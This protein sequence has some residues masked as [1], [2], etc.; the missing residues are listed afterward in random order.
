MTVTRQPSS[1]AKRTTGSAS[2]P[3]PNSR[4]EESQT[5]AIEFSEGAFDVEH[6]GRL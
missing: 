6:S 1:L 4:S 2:K 3:A 5:A